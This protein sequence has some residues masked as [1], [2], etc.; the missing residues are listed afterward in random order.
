MVEE[1]NLENQEKKVLNVLPLGKGRRILLFL[2]DFFL[3][4]VLSWVLFAV[5]VLPI[6]KVVTS[7]YAKNNDYIVN[8]QERGE[9]LYGNKILFESG[10]VDKSEIVYNASFTYFCYLSYFCFDEE[11]PQNVEYSQYGHKQENDIFKHYYLDIINDEA[12]FIRLFDLYNQKYSYFVRDGLNITLKDEMKYQIYAFFDTSDQESA[13]ADT[14]IEN[15]ETSVFYPLYSEV[16]TSIDKNDLMY[17]GKSYK[18]VEQKI[19][20]FEN[21]VNV[22]AIVNAFIAFGISTA[23]LYLIIPLFNRNHKTLSMMILKI[24]KVNLASLEI[25]KKPFVVISFIYALISN[26][27]IIFFAPIGFLTI[28]EVF[29]L[30]VILTFSLLSIM[31]MLASFIF[32]MFNQYNLDLFDYLTRSVHLKTSDLDDI[33]RAKGYYV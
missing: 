26:M 5:A 1:E 28:Y 9:I 15:I 33:Y 17:E 11:N 23:V 29:N 14:Y 21:Y 10:N 24:E 8:R 13:V 12:S 27:L 2:A 16:M 19:D 32:L 3:N 30:P 31:M 22:L 25:V 7:Y 18:A 6:A 20:V 4:F